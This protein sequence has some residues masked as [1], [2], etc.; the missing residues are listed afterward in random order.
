MFWEL[1]QWLFHI[2]NF[3]LV[4]K[5]F[6]K[7]SEKPDYSDITNITNKKI[8]YHIEDCHKDKNHEN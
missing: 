4:L 6:A 8:I 7:I 1:A 5:C 2:L 3:V